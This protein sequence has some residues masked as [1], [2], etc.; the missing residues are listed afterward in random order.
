MYLNVRY[1]ILRV[2]KCDFNVKYKSVR[3]TVCFTYIST[4]NTRLTKTLSNKIKAL[5]AILV[6]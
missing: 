6:K 2:S 5:T 3:T 1:F 4:N